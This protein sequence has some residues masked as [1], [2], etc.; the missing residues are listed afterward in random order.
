MNQHRMLP[1]PIRMSLAGMRPRTPTN[2]DTTFNCETAKTRISVGPVWQRGE[3]D[4]ICPLHAQRGTICK[5]TPPADHWR[6][7]RLQGVHMH[8]SLVEQQFGPSAKAYAECEV[9]R[10]GAS[11]ARLIELAQP[12]AHWQAL[13]VGHPAPATPPWLSLHTSLT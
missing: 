6:Q 12:Q 4:I 7:A 1:A 11:L 10:S 13:D 3:Y 5:D 8:K 2:S 9:H